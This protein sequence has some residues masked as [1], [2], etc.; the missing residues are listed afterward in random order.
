MGK[1]IYQTADPAFGK[2]FLAVSFSILF[3]IIL[4]STY[5]HHFRPDILQVPSNSDVSTWTNTP[6]EHTWIY[7]R[8]T[9][10]EKQ[11]IRA[12]GIPGNTFADLLFLE[13]SSLFV[14]LL[15]FWHVRRHYGSWM[16]WCFILRSI[17]VAAGE[18]QTLYIP[19]G[20]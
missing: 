6:L 1:A 2:K 20:W 10:A 18:Q 4:F 3:I 14:A 13:I 12:E 8:M 9:E 5:L 11:K 7:E 16:T 15:C 17:L 19:P